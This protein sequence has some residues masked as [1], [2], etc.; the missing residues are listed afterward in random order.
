MYFL[1]LFVSVSIVFHHNTLLFAT[2]VLE[3]QD[4]MGILQ[5]TGMGTGGPTL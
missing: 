2:V 4:L 5:R 3:T 1:R